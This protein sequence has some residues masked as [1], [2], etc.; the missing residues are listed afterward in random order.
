MLEGV[1]AAQ[2]RRDAARSEAAVGARRHRAPT[3]P[4]TATQAHRDLRILIEGRQR[5]DAAIARLR[6][7]GARTE[8]LAEYV[9]AHRL[10]WV[11]PRKSTLRGDTRVWRLGELLLAPDGELF[12]TGSVVRVGEPQRARVPSRAQE[13]R[14][15]FR[16]AAR[17]AGAGEGET[18]DVGATRI[19]WESEALRKGAHPVLLLDEEL[20]V[21][22]GAGAGTLMPF[23]EYLE[24][25][26]EHL[27]D[28]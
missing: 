21:R 14:R 6:A 1:D 2:Q 9:P 7:N 28:S 12:S 26:L 13:V 4:I 25:R 24:D 8:T 27:L 16:A 22:W 23:G 11:I 17:R 15:E 19:P 3:E 10:L 18:V 5:V 20:V